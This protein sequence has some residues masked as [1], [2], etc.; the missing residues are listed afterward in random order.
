MIEYKLK[1]YFQ[2]DGSEDC[3]PISSL[4]ILDYF[5]ITSDRK[6]VLKKVQRS[7]FGTS[8]FAN[9]LT[10]MEYGLDTELV[11]IQP[12]IFV[13]EFIK[14]RPS[15]AQIIKKVSECKS[16][17][18]IRDKKSNLSM[19]IDYLRSGGKFRLAIPTKQ[20]IKTALDSGRLIWISAYTKIL[21]ENE[22][23][24]HSSVIAGYKN[25]EF[26]IY[27]PWPRSRK[28]SWENADEVMFAIHSVTD[29]DYDNGAII[30]VGKK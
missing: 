14:S 16:I 30:I 6:E 3:G 19:F 8:T 21:G 4:M 1:Q 22:G 23:G 26:L 7:N 18:K 24:H 12:K 20:M 29:F 11:T 5:G 10:L 9:A 15:M 17:E 13:G 25:N 2:D 28:K 27:N